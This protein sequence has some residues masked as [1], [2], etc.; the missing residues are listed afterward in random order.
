M[1]AETLFDLIIV[2]SGPGGE[3]AAMQAAKEGLKVA[4]VEKSPMVGGSCTH[5]GT[6][7]SK[8]LRQ[9]SHLLTIYQDDLLFNRGHIFP[10]IGFSDFL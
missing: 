3:G 8:S 9:M 5:L 1:T 4:L 7:P 6:I 10:D 2:G